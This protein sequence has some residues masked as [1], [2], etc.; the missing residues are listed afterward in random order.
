MH[1]T[2]ENGG[3]SLEETV[4][5]ALDV[6]FDAPEASGIGNLGAWGYPAAPP[7]DGLIMHKCVDAAAGSRSPPV[8]PPCGASA[9]P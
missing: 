1:V 3:K 8:R 4:G 5:A 7:Y 6:D 9:A 2:P